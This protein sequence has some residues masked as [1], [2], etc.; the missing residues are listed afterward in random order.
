MY[1]HKRNLKNI[2]YCYFPSHLELNNKIP[3]HSS[4]DCFYLALTNLST[5]YN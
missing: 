5:Y 2:I 1:K 3:C 4:K